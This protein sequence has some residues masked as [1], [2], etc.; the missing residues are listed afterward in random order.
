MK[1]D[2]IFS[3]IT[4]TLNSY[5]NLLQL[6]DNLESIEDLPYQHIVID[7]ASKDRTVDLLKSKS[8][9]VWISEADDGIYE[10]WNKG[11]NLVTT[12]WVSFLGAD[13]RIVESGY[14]ELIRTAMS[15]PNCDYISGLTYI[16]RNHKVIR[17]TGSPWKWKQF[18]RFHCTGHI[19][20]FHNVRLFN[21]YGNYDTNFKIV[22]DYEFLLRIGANLKSEFID[23]VTCRMELGGVSNKTPKPIFETH[24]AKVKN[25]STNSC[26]A[27]IDLI[28]AL[29]KWYIKRMLGKI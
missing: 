16:T 2:P 26:L 14:R 4:S 22:G 9:V 24:R 27:S 5:E 13:D 23:K 6:F 7:G 3:I 1:N 19:G 17:T 8:N 18:K 29:S 21:N 12:D 25:K 28:T 10:A 15:K 20:A 11:L